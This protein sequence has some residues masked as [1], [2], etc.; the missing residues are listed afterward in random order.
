MTVRWATDDNE[1]GAL[2]AA[3]LVAALKAKPALTLALPSGRTPLGLYARLRVLHARGEWAPGAL[4]AFALDE[5]VGI[6]PDDAESF[7]AY[8]RRELGEPLGLSGTQLNLLDGQA[9]DPAAAAAA[10]EA[11]IE[12]LGGLDLAVLGLGANG[13]VAFNEPG[14]A[15]DSP[16][17]VVRLSDDT[18]RRLTAGPFAARPAPAEGMTLGLR[19]LVQARAVLL[20]VSG[21]DKA[22]ALARLLAGVPSPDWP[23]S[24]F[25]GHPDLTVIATESLRPLP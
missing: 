15:T 1:L 21:A 7:S 11:A 8:F 23:V 14:S 9:T 6:A 13:H 12:R 16:A 19:C 4:H 2:A 24:A 10:H 18:V 3:V 20:L 22:P 5:Y 25:I 17:R